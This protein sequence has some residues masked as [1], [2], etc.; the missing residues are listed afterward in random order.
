MRDEEICNVNNIMRARAHAGPTARLVREIISEQCASHPRR[1]VRVLSSMS[2]ENYGKS[3]AEKDAPCSRVRSR[4]DLRAMHSS[5][6]ASTYRVQPTCVYNLER[7]RVRDLH[8][9]TTPA[10]R[11][12]SG[13]VAS[14]TRPRPH[15]EHVRPALIP[16]G[17]KR[18]TPRATRRREL[19]HSQP[20]VGTTRQ[21]R[22]ASG[23][24]C[25]FA[26]RARLERA[27]FDSRRGV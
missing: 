9:T 6:R 7:N 13:R 5:V 3:P 10:A 15:L 17:G 14:A 24:L 19:S 26:N 23:D 21:A 1:A 18:I 27:R 22:N 20:L 8:A 16:L 12:R 25:F 2:F 4:A 11:Q